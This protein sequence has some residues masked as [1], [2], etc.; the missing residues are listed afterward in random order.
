MKSI[1]E[2][3]SSEIVIKNS[4]F[5]G[6]LYKLNSLEDINKYLNI[7]KETYKDA[8]HYPYAYIYNG[9]IKCSDDKEPS[10]T[11]GNVILNILKKNELNFVLCVVVRYFGKIKLGAGGLIR[12]YANS[13]K[14]TINKSEIIPLTM[15]INCDISF[16]YSLKKEV[17]YILTNSNIIKESYG[18][19]ISY[20]IETVDNVLDKLKE[21]NIEIYNINYKYIE[22]KTY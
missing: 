10:G 19:K 13:T 5:I 1:K 9:Y 11:A 17:N 16:D 12:A 7:V 21:P 20:N 15:G 8:T 18:N 14:F 4:R 22:K 2:N 6:V 3:V